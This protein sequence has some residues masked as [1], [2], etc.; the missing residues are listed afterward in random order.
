MHFRDA[1]G[2]G[3]WELILHEEILNDPPWIKPGAVHLKGMPR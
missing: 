3:P 2:D 1:A